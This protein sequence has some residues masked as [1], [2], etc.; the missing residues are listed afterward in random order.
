MRKITKKA[1]ISS[2]K[3]RVKQTRKVI[4]GGNKKTRKSKKNKKTTQKVA[5]IKRNNKK[6]R[7]GQT[8]GGKIEL[9]KTLL[10]ED[11]ITINEQQINRIHRIIE[12]MGN[13]EANRIKLKEAKQFIEKQISYVESRIFHISQNII[14]KKL[15]IF[16]SYNKREK[17]KKAIGKYVRDIKTNNPNN[18]NDNIYVDN[19]YLKL[20]DTAGKKQQSKNKA[21][22]TKAKITEL[23]NVIKYSIQN[24]IEG[25]L[26][27]LG[28]SKELIK[29]KN[30]I[31]QYRLKYEKNKTN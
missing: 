28:N 17:L 22:K 15:Y 19:L 30:D 9:L 12:S 1:N 16:F 31:V 4:K 3:K 23:K 2:S 13:I 7:K 29:L 8:G 20:L 11:N 14:E 6:T 18:P 26:I 10:E 25:A 27:L 24:G 5:R 21:N